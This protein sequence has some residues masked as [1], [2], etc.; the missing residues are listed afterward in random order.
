M[1][2]V[3]VNDLSLQISQSREQFFHSFLTY[4]SF[5]CADCFIDSL[6]DFF[7]ILPVL[8]GWHPFSLNDL[9]VHE[10][11]I[12]SFQNQTDVPL[13]FIKFLFLNVMPRT[14]QC[15]IFIMY[16]VAKRENGHSFMRPVNHITILVDTDASMIFQNLLSYHWHTRYLKCLHGWNT[17]FLVRREFNKLFQILECHHNVHLSAFWLRAVWNKK[18]SKSCPRLT[19]FFWTGSLRLLLLHRYFMIHF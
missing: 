4:H 12:L 19:R 14:L 9:V 13:V 18:C 10:N 1:E 15:I 5:Q 6:Q 8:T 2:Q 3:D 7:L 17:L 11:T 16:A